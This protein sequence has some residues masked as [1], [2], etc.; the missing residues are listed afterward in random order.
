MTDRAVYS[1][2]VLEKYVLEELPPEQIASIRRQAEQDKA[3][4]RRIEQ[5][6]ESNIQFADNLP[7]RR[8]LDSIRQRVSASAGLTATL[9]SR[10]QPYWVPALAIA[11]TVVIALSLVLL[12]QTADKQLEYDEGGIDGVRLKGLEPTLILYKQSAS[13]AKVL[14]DGAPVH[15]GD[16]VQLAY[17]AAGY[18]YGA[19][20][21]VDGNAAV[22][23]HFPASVIASTQLG[24]QGENRL[25][26]SYQLDDAPAFERFYFIVSDQ[27][28]VPATLLRDL[29]QSYQQNINA[30]AHQFLQSL[31]ASQT[32]EVFTLMKA[33]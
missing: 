1:D 8:A 29:A 32:G 30:D 19:I 25:A 27:P 9:S 17:I 11:A 6:H 21:S 22:T 24:Q 4:R 26:F 18:Q 7:A 3:L 2:L 16:T 23:L 12:P 20:V 10:R 13:V 15:A 14:S 33:D 31:P 5:I 28:I